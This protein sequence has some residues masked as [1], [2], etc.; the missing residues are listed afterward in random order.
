MPQPLSV[1]SFKGVVR[2]PQA[3]KIEN[4]AHVLFENVNLQEASIRGNRG[5]LKQ[6]LK[7]I[8]DLGKNGLFYYENSTGQRELVHCDASSINTL[9]INPIC[10]G[11]FSTT[12]G[13]QLAAGRAL[14]IDQSQNVFVLELSTSNIKKYDKNGALLSTI[15][16]PSSYIGDSIAVDEQ[17]FI[18][19]TVT[20]GAGYK[21]FKLTSAG[22][23]VLEIA[24]LAQRQYMTYKQG[25]LYIPSGVDLEVYDT[26]TLVLDSTISGTAGETLKDLAV[27]PDGNVYAVWDD[28]TN[29]GI[30]KI[31]A[32]TM[33]KIVST[34]TNIVGSLA[35]DEFE[36]I[37]LGYAPSAGS[38]SVR[39]Y[40]SNGD[41]LE[42]FFERAADNTNFFK[43]GTIHIG[44]FTNELII[45][46]YT[47]AN[48]QGLK[49]FVFVEG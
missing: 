9:Y 35:I 16:I 17:G 24:V 13:A 39:V 29:R 43:T 34:T 7:A 31:T 49:F 38:R 2:R 10:A 11:F 6:N 14:F 36:R 33:T 8:T 19:V 3:D 30:K 27:S 4:G 23:M 18:Y 45:H 46:D 20:L 15:T 22:T 41:L 48:F 32:S 40:Q 42:E 44:T 28:G 37:W 25:R 5:R 26:S 1:D 21:L 12:T 47:A